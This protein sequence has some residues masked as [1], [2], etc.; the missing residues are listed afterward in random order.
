MCLTYCSILLTDCASIGT[1]RED[2]LS[3][4]NNVIE[5]SEVIAVNEGL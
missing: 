5:V 3:E 2:R 4:V 1:S